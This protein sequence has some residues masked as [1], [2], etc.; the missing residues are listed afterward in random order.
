LQRKYPWQISDGNIRGKVATETSVANL[1]F[2]S[3]TL[4]RDSKNGAK[5]NR[6]KKNFPRNYPWLS[7][8]DLAFA[9]LFHIITIFLRNKKRSLV[10]DGMDRRYLETAKSVASPFPY[11]KGIKKKKY[12]PICDGQVRRYPLPYNNNFLKI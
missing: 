8:T 3:Q 10:C 7:C 4:I 5:Q 12:I 9:A 1:R 11:N 6:A 2:S